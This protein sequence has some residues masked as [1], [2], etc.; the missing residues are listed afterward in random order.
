MHSREF[1]MMILTV[2]D[3]EAVKICKV[4]WALLSVHVAV[5]GYQTLHQYIHRSL[6]A[7]QVGVPDLGPC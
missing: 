6:N 4:P 7:M 5:L 3:I 1:L 2:K